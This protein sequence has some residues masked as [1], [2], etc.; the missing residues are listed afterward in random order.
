MVDYS[1]L[2]GGASFVSVI[3]A[4]LAIGG[5]LVAVYVVGIGVKKVLR[6][7]QYRE[8][9]RESRAYARKSWDEGRKAG[10]W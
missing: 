9:Q 1:G 3:V 2:V 8:Y 6:T 10:R 7:L 5:V 4:V